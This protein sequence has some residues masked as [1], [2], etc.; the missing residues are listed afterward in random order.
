VFELVEKWGTVDRLVKSLTG[1]HG[2]DISPGKEF[3]ATD[4]S[5]GVRKYKP[6]IAGGIE[7]EV[8]ESKVSPKA[9]IPDVPL[10][11]F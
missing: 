10:D 9:K 11:I 7:I 4:I 3:T 5:V 1:T 2:W 8:A 6:N